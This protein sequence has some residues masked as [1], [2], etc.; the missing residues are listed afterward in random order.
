[1]AELKVSLQEVKAAGTLTPK[2]TGPSENHPRRRD[3]KTK[4]DRTSNAASRAHANRQARADWQNSGG[5]FP[6][7][8]CNGQRNRHLFTGRG[9]RQVVLVKASTGA[10]PA[11]GKKK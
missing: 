3:G 6:Y 7:A 2:K 10:A 1:M 4:K 5:E 9:N 11:K 8:H